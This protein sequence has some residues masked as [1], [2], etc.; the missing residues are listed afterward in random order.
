LELQY[1]HEFEGVQFIRYR[2]ALDTGDDEW[3][4]PITPNKEQSFI[5]AIGAADATYDEDVR[6]G[7]VPDE[8]WYGPKI[9]QHA[10]NPE[11]SYS[12]LSDVVL[13]PKDGSLRRECYTLPGLLVE[14]EMTVSEDHVEFGER[15]EHNASLDKLETVVFYWTMN[16]TTSRVTLG[17]R[18]AR[19]DVNWISL[20][21]GP[22]MIGSHAYVGWTDAGEGRV[23]AYDMTSLQAEGVTRK[24][25][26]LGDV[27]ITKS[28]EG[29]TL[30]F[31]RPLGTS[32]IAPPIEIGNAEVIWAFGREWTDDGLDSVI[33][34]HQD[35]SG[36][37][38][39]HNLRQ[40]V[41]AKEVSSKPYRLH[42][43]LM[44]GSMAGLLPIALLVSQL[45]TSHSTCVTIVSSILSLLAIAVALYGV[46]EV[47]TAKRAAGLPG[48]LSVDGTMH[49]KIGVS[50]LAI[51][52]LVILVT[53]VRFCRNR[54]PTQASVKV[55]SGEDQVLAGGAKMGG[56]DVG[57][58]LLRALGLGLAFAAVLTGISHAAP[59]LDL[60]AAA[61]LVYMEATAAWAT[62]LV[63]LV[64]GATMLGVMSAGVISVPRVKSI[65]GKGLLVA[66]AVVVTL[67][68]VLAATTHT[69]ASP[70]LVAKLVVEPAAT[71]PRDVAF[72]LTDFP[73]WTAPLATL[74]PSG[75]PTTRS[76]TPESLAVTFTYQLSGEVAALSAVTSELVA[77]AVVEWSALLGASVRR[78]QVAAVISP[79]GKSRE[80]RVAV[81]GVPGRSAIRILTDSAAQLPRVL[82]AV[83]VES[84]LNLEAV[85]M[86]ASTRAQFTVVLPSTLSPTVAPVPTAAPT[87]D[88]CEDK[89]LPRSYIGD[90]WCDTSFNTAGCFYDGGDCCD[91]RAGLFDCRDPSHKSVGQSSPKATYP[92][93]RNPRYESR[94]EKIT[95]KE[96]A[97]GYNNFYEF[98]Y[99]KLVTPTIAPYKEFFNASTWE[100]KISGLVDNPMTLSAEALMNM[101]HFEERMYQHRCVEAWS[102]TMPW[103]GFPLS[104]LVDLVKPN[105]EAKYIKFTSFLNFKISKTQ[106]QDVHY[107]WPY[108]EGLTIDEAMN[109]LAFVSVGQHQEPITEQVGA[110][111]R[112]TV[113]WKYG[114]KGV[115][116]IRSIEF[117]TERPVTFWE[118]S[119][120][121]REYGFWANIDP[122]VPHAR[123]S[124]ASEAY[125]QDQALQAERVPTALYNGYE[126]E[127]S[128]LYDKLV[129]DGVER[130]WY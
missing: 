15:F 48:P 41:G 115:K 64:A 93:P 18:I 112:L 105:P 26:E 127:V 38:S 88:Y 92:A 12:E 71:V 107:P 65:Y 32:G 22:M 98:G 33:H 42:G 125:R 40:A 74:A 95:T 110:P 78:D 109:E 113:P 120:G 83:G 102:M 21:F 106:Q 87:I 130:M 29:M 81:S 82:N 27:E 121:G 28:S 89:D 17:L 86:V 31:S 100:V 60:P 49:S 16:K 123:W 11:V 25:E 108:V 52:G 51:T 46:Y 73:D 63:L 124:Q 114:F 111:I 8:A 37:A 122:G 76:P 39:Y 116:S 119:T 36:K 104:K 128:Y 96:Y 56:V 20:G 1:A 68:A 50:A 58:G 80:L 91:T 69:Q 54:R 47:A 2:R 129:D 90:G 53:N 10:V 62:G 7:L 103:V 94:F 45:G 84:T 117:V 57:V 59:Y 85:V 99:S 97:N 70:L 23:D 35:R 77:K 67:A 19:P 43:L 3:D 34:T 30:T 13:L 24:D 4:H 126:K 14:S 118:E 44:W 66:A 79:R 5:W 55:A 101:F 72:L 61:V 75:P 9:R 6:S